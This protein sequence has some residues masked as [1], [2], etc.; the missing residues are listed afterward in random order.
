MKKFLLPL[1][2]L[3]LVSKIASA[4][5]LIAYS[6]LTDDYWQ[7]WVMTPEGTD[8]RQLTFSLQDKRDPAWIHQGNALAFRTNN[9]QLFTIDRNGQN[10]TRILEQYG[11]INSPHFCDAAQEIVFV[12]F[13]PATADISD[14]WKTDLEGKRPLLLTKQNKFVY[15]P[16]F[17]PDGKHIVFVQIADNKEDQHLWIMS[18][19]DRPNRSRYAGQAGASGGGGD[20][21]QPRSLTEGPGKDALPHF[22]PSGRDITFT[23]NRQGNYD[24]YLLD[25]QN[26]KVN[27]VTQYSGLDTSSSFSPDG[28]HIVFVSNRGGNQQIW[29]MGKDGSNPAQLTFGQDESIDPA[30][31]K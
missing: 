17:S 12:R 6:H 2:I 16:S 27:R 13:D 5:E 24:I 10:E 28:E 4:E 9:G 8:Q 20:G 18:L 23:S 29:V 19:P 30:W 21:G 11:V 25:V 1:F 26:G 31:G 22:S 15:Q 3:L 14:L 7:I